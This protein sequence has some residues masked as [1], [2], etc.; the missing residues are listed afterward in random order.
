M[1]SEDSVDHFVHLP[2]TLLSLVVHRIRDFHDGRQSCR[3]QVQSGLEEMHRIFKEVHVWPARREA[4]VAPHERQKMS[5]DRLARIDRED[6]DVRV[7]W[8][9][10]DPAALKDLLSHLEKLASSP[11]LIHEELRLYVKAE[12]VVWA[13]LHR[14]A[15][16][17]LSL[18]HASQKP[19]T[20]L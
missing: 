8:L 17:S 16:A 15:P 19:A 7:A 12:R 14:D 6:Q 13:P 4:H 10:P 18:N 1:A 11:M 5:R 3:P 9:W 20:L 2:T